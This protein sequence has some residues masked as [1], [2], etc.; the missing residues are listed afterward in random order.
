MVN[1]VKYDENEIE[2]DEELDEGYEEQEEEEEEEEEEIQSV[3]NNYY[4]ARRRIEDYME[5]RRMRNE[6]DDPFFDYD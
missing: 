5:L 1:F 2:S 3:H 6:L 4:T